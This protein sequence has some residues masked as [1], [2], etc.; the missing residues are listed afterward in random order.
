MGNIRQTLTLLEEDAHNPTLRTHKLKGRLNG[1]WSSTVQ[2]DLRIVFQFVHQ[3][4]SEAILLGD[5][6]THEEVY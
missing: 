6:G 5:I 4:G 2:Y 1:N 3:D